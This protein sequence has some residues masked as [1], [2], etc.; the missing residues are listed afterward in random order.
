MRSRSPTSQ[1]RNAHHPASGYQSGAT[2]RPS[3]TRATLLGLFLILTFGPALSA[4]AFE[5]KEP[6]K[7]LIV[8]RHAC[9]ASHCSDPSLNSI[10]R[11]QAEKLALDLYDEDE[12]DNIDAIFVT[13]KQRTQETAKPLADRLNLPPIECSRAGDSDPCISPDEAGIRNLLSK[14]CSGD[15]AGQVVLHVGH[16]NTLPIL[17]REL[18]LENPDAYLSAQPW[19]IV[20]DENGAPSYEKV[21]LE[22]TA[23]HGSGGCGTRPCPTG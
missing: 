15:Y 7:A 12:D 9:K 6:P 20:F 5:C 13:T 16:S 3:C 14:L 2:L 11:E 4:Q 21:E 19:E 18:G 23:P 17:F 1:P 22:H 10:G 8:T